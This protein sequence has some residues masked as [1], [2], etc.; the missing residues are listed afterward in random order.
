MALRTAL[1]TGLAALLIWPAIHLTYTV[2]DGCS[3]A[4]ETADAAVVL[5]SKVN[6]DGTLS[7]RL[8]QR[9]NCGLQLYRSRRAP[10]IIVSGGLGREGYCEG[11][12][13]KEYLVQH[14]VPNAAIII[15]NHGDNTLA[16][17]QNV[18]RMQDNL[19]F[20]KLIIVSQYFH[21]T[22]TKKLFRQHHFPAVSSVSPRYVELRNVYAMPREF[23]AY[24]AE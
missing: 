16:T 6:P 12:K 22:R 23:I 4:G 1:R 21:L 7:T 13:M 2:I 15:D 18:L 9:L 20:N 11:D 24:Y 14:G 3:D 5:G 17:V 19:K 10:K 8:E